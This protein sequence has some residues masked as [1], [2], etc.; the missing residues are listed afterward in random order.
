MNKKAQAGTSIA[1]RIYALL[2]CG[3]IAF[4]VSGC[5][6]FVLW[7]LISATEAIQS[8]SDLEI[9]PLNSTVAPGQTLQ[10]LASGGE[11]PYIFLVVSGDGS[12]DAETGL[13]SA[14]SLISV[15]IVRVVDST[16]ETSDAQVTTS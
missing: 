13:Y 1:A 8:D 9:S 12:I 7:D 10:F 6:S 5:D 16:G 3:A 2:V 14:P 11:S 4:V 15:D